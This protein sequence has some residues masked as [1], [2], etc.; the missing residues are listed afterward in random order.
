M[1]PLLMKEGA[2]PE[3]QPER[4]RVNG[5]HDTIRKRRLFQ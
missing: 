1:T 4:R 2:L 3:L 5:E